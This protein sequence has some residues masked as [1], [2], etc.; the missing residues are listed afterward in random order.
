M[1]GGHALRAS[2]RVLGVAGGL[3]MGASFGSERAQGQ[4]LTAGEIA[5]LQTE[6]AYAHKTRSD[7]DDKT[8]P[9]AE[10]TAPASRFYGGAEYLLWWVKGAPLGVPLVTTGPAANNYGFI[11]N[12]STT[13]LYGAPFAPATGGNS[14]QTFP[15]FSGVRLT[16]GYWLDDGHRFAIE[17]RG[18]GLQQRAAGFD[19]RGDANG[20][21][22]MRIPVFNTVP[23]RPG[24]AL[25]LTISENGLPISLPG[26]LTGAVN[27]TNS[28]RLWGLDGAGIFNIFR[29]P[30]WE[31]SALA[32]VRYL[33]LTESF[34]LKDDIVGLTSIFAGQSGEVVDLFGTH[35]QFY[36]GTLGLR[37]RAASGPLSAELTGRLSL[38]VSHEVLNIS[39]AFQAV[40]FTSSAGSQGIFAQPSNSGQRSSDAFA[41]VPELQAKL[42]YQLTPAI[43]LT[44]GYDLL[45]D[46]NVVRPGDQISRNLPKGQVFQQGGTSISATSPVALFNTTDF[47]VQGLSVGLAIEF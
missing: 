30:S 21:P 3:L 24:S 18:F 38:G 33:D 23:Y 7:R 14:T 26:I 9:P 34:S 5:A 13:V 32:G 25:D 28:L 29:T 8:W 40:N 17:G 11:L 22:G 45:Y 12:S 6:L 36:G 15:G 43:R 44:A 31:L 46:S 27:V 10:R 4:T 39:G 41:A 1:A 16:A 42:G 35:N 47:F 2:V 37:G 19:A 20:S